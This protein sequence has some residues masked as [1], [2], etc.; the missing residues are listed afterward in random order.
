MRAMCISR[1]KRTNLTDNDSFNIKHFYPTKSTL[2]KHSLHSTSPVRISRLIKETTILLLGLN[3]VLKIL[4]AL[5]HLVLAFVLFLVL[6]RSSCSADLVLV[7]VH[8]LAQILISPRDYRN[9]PSMSLVQCSV[10]S[11]MEA[12]TQTR[13]SLA[14]G[15]GHEMS[16]H[17]VFLGS[18]MIW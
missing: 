15:R 10:T 14:I 16:G 6:V 1:I 18:I 17:I 7:Y 12:Y 3:S 5:L 4:P 13:N 9:C 2:Q 11:H 8:D